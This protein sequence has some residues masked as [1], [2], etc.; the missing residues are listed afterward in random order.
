MNPIIIDQQYKDKEYHGLEPTE[1]FYLDLIC[2]TNSLKIYKI[3]KEKCVCFLFNRIQ[4]MWR[5]AM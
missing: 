2:K 4:K 5:L 3:L 1:V